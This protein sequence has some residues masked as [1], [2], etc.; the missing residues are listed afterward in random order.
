MASFPVA[1]GKSGDLNNFVNYSAPVAINDNFDD[2][3]LFISTKRKDWPVQFL[4]NLIIATCSGPQSFN[5]L[6]LSKCFN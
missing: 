2:A 5:F 4:E 1:Y 3:R 6:Q